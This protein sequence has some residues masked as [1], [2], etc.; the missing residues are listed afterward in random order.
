MMFGF[1]LDINKME[2]VKTK[3]ALMEVMLLLIPNSKC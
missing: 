2:N 1:Y 3:K